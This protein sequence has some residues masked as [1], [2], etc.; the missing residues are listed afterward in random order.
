MRTDALTVGLPVHNAMPFLPETIASLLNQ[1]HRDFRILI[2]DDG[3]TD[4]SPGY[5][6]TVKDS[7]VRLLRQ[8]NHG[9]AYTLNRMLREADTPW[10]LRHDADD[11]AYPNKVGAVIGHI[12]RFPSSGMFYSLADYYQD[13][14]SFGSFR[15]T[16]A[17][18][19]VL[20]NLTR[21]GYLLAIC[22]PAAALNIEKTLA[23]GGYRFDLH[24][25]DIDLWWRM[26]L[27]HD[28]VLIPEVTVGVRHNLSSVC[29]GNLETNALNTLYVQYQLISYLWGLSP[30]PYE[31]ATKK[32]GGLMDKR[33]LEFR[34]HIRKAS[35]HVGRRQYVRAMGHAARSFLTAPG[36]F[37]KRVAYELGRGEIAVNGLEPKVFASMSEAL[38]RTDQALFCG[39]K[40]ERTYPD[41]R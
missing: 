19:S 25:E 34:W 38:W 8:E 17:P 1:D 2:I 29:G 33:Q 27:L 22:H 41:G 14:R 31:E 40:G 20:A 5:L 30:L 18:P 32:L 28:M 10:L 12:R 7:R 11:I 21:A 37:L 13:G 9:L 23:L 36:Y 24:I 4:G 26:A 16:I 15:T 6:E 39:I 3:S 35:A